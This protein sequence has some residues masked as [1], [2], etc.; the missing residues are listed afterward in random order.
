MGGMGGRA[1][2]EAEVYA[3][4]ESCS[5]LGVAGLTGLL[6]VLLLELCRV[7][8]I[9]CLR[10]DEG[11]L[12]P[13]KGLRLVHG[14]LDEVA[15]ADIDQDGVERCRLSRHVE[16]RGDWDEHR[17]ALR[18]AREPAERLLRGRQLIA[19]DLQLMD[20]TVKPLQ[21]LFDALLQL[22]QLL[23]AE[24]EQVDALAPALGHGV[25]KFPAQV[26][27]APVGLHGK[28]TYYST[29]TVVVQQ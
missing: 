15:R 16:R 9:D 20:G 28:T 10:L 26:C 19:R 2:K 6:Q 27:V 14:F 29:S 11:H 17:R 12:A 18:R 22:I 23:Q 13:K 21:L 5:G 7:L 8:H 25:C 1:G 24:S 3:R 4:H